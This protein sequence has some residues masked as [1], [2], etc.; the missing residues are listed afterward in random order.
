[1]VHVDS[2]GTESLFNNDFEEFVAWAD[3]VYRK[4]LSSFSKDR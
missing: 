2:I 4:E 3:G 1:M